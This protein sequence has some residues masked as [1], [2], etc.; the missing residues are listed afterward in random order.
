MFD[1]FGFVSAI[2]WQVVD[3]HADEIAKI[4]GVDEHD[5]CCDNSPPGPRVPHGWKPGMD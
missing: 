2:D 5:G 3:D 1:P 4:L